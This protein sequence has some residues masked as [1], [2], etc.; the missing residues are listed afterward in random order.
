MPRRNLLILLLAS[1]VSYACYVRG[2]QNPYVRFVAD[3]LAAIDDNS[4]E[5][6]PD[7]ELFN[8]AM[9]G[10]VDVLNKRGDEHS[11]FLAEDEAEPLRSEIRQQFGGIGV[12][13]GFEGEPAQLTIVAPPHPGS[14]ASNANILPGDRILAIDGKSTE[15]M[16]MTDV[17]HFIRGPRGTEVS[18][19]I[20]S[21]HVGK[22]R[23][24]ELTREVINIESVLGDRRDK[25][26]RWLFQLEAYPRT[27][28]IRIAS[29]GD[30][31]AAELDRAL[32]QVLT[33]GAKA[34][35]LDLRDD[36]GGSLEA[37]VAIC[38]MFLPGGKEIVSTRGRDPDLNQQY[39]SEDDGPYLRLPL[40]VIVNQHS[41]SASEIVAACLQDH[42]RAMV[43]G[44]RSYGKGT[45]QQLLPL[46][47]GRS[48]LKLT[49]ASFWRPSGEKIHRDAGTNDADTWGV[50]PNAGGERK[51]TKDEYAAFQKYRADRDLFRVVSGSYKA[52]ANSPTTATT[53]VDQQLQ[54]A[55]KYLEGV[56]DGEP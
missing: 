3:G 49:W 20:Q 9:D 11:E 53:F 28:H 14:P 36:S 23:T 39:A 6:I 29:F 41:A 46:E 8:G 54:D 10:M 37:A 2:E 19:T 50:A 43:F 24:V 34:L 1:V 27:A 35:V 21:Q 30:R 12:R 38:Q 4:L 25:N 16:K 5:A 48:L 15:G 18:L 56:L 17:L 32:K 13:I 42:H 22:P 44:E 47:S 31:T 51:L 55:V 26:G 45:V 33:S 40:A 7:R 52:T